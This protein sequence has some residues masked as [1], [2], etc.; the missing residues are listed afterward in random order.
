MQRFHKIEDSAV[1]VKAR[2]TYYQRDAYRRGDEL[3]VKHGSGFIRLFA[4][5]SAGAVGGGTSV[6]AI[7]WVEMDLG[8]LSYGHEKGV[9][10][11]LVFDGPQRLEAAE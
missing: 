11:L 1:I 10:G 8:N 9:P 5:P 2:G 4:S 7:S 3:F 6:P